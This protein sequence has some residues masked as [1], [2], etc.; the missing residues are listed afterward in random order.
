MRKQTVYIALLAL[1]AVGCSSDDETREATVPA[2]EPPVEQ[3]ADAIVLLA[4]MGSADVTRGSQD[5][6]TAAF[7]EGELVSV[8]VTP[9]GST[10]QASVYRAAAADEEHRNVLTAYSRAVTWPA[11][12]GSVGIRAYYPS[13]V[14]SST[15]TFSVQADQSSDDNYKLS[16][17]MY[18][19]PVANQ[20]KA[21]SV[22]LTFHHALSKVVVKLTAGSGADDA[23]LSHCAVAVKACKTAA[24]SGGVATPVADATAAADYGYI[25]IGTGAA[26]AGIIVPQTID[27]SA[28]AQPFVRVT[29]GEKHLYYKLRTR[30]AFEARKMYTYTLRVDLGEVILL[31]AVVEDWNEVSRDLNF[32]EK[33]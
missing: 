18:A 17:L 7:D 33:P 21:A 11:N 1:L 8:E 27:G 32:T 10:M 26:V 24:L 20:A 22:P 15:A 3:P 30:K 19:E 6:Q 25:K 4:S 28:T 31:S 12:N 13:T 5:V 23:M 2:E 29:I 14:T 9:S 16:D